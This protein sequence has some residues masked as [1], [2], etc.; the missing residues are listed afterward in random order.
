MNMK[1]Q[2]IHTYLCGTAQD[3]EETLAFSRKHS[4][5]AIVEKY[6]FEQAEEAYAHHAKA[7]FRAVVITL[8]DKVSRRGHNCAQLFI[9]TPN[10]CKSFA[11]SPQPTH[12]GVRHTVSA[13]A[14]YNAASYSYTY[15]LSFSFAS[16]NMC[17]I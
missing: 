6:P 3:C 9:E 14:L 12:T 5:K 7:R 11:R 10:L 4:I 2:S 15:P 16:Q 8:L 17:H 13:F 1:R